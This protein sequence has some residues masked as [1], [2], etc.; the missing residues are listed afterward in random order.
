MEVEETASKYAQHAQH[1][2]DKHYTYADYASWDDE[3]RYELIDGEVFM[4]SAPSVMH[5]RI[6]G[7]FLM[8]IATVL[9]R[10]RCEPFI[11][12]LDVCLNAKGDD[13]DTVV[14]PDIIVVCEQS[15]LDEKR[16]NGA[17]DL[18][19]EVVSPSTSRHDR[20]RKLNK[21][22]Q[23]GVREFWIADPDDKSVTTHIL[24]DGKYVVNAYEDAESVTVSVLEGCEISLPEV[25]AD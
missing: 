11:A 19:I 22:L 3:N 6:V 10:K 12:P 8:Q 14:Q 24:E 1:A 5:Q 23:A 15:K 7:R 21:Y 13:D 2:Q 16:C 4:M 17:P 20:I 9:D 18:V 25:F